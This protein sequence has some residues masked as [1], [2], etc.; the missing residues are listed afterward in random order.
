MFRKNIITDEALV[1]S[2]SAGGRSEARALEYLID[3][4]YPKVLHFVLQ[5]GGNDAD[6]DDVFQEAL[7][8]LVLNIRRSQ[9]KGESA[10]GTYLFA[11]AKGVWFKRI[12]KVG[13][14][15]DRDQEVGRSSETVD[16]STP[17]TPM[18]AADK[19]Q[20]LLEVFENLGEKCPDVLFLW[21]SGYNMEEIALRAGYSSAQAAMNRKN[22]CLKALHA[23]MD[24][25]PIL[26]DLL[27]NLR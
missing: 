10:L 23:Q 7:T 16:L 11:I 8:A 6:A 12:R 1:K 24:D 17:E 26:V 5:H 18:I 19:R 22:K 25:N 4:E 20:T 3:K 2:I 15:R 27:K 21:A 13:R 14:D 9:Y